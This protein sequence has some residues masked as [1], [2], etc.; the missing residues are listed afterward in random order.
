MSIR[1][2]LILIFFVLI[3]LKR[4]FRDIKLYGWASRSIMISDRRPLMK[5]RL[6]TLDLFK[7]LHNAH[8]TK[9]PFE[10]PKASVNDYVQDNMSN[11]SALKMY[12]G[13]RSVTVTSEL[14]F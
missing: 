8:I 12:F 10:L 1:L 5:L 11:L 3:M 6:R 13:I 7:R 14:T 4:T 2:T 9:L